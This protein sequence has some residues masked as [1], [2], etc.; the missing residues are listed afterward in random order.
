MQFYGNLQANQNVLPLIRDG[1]RLV[2]VSSS[3]GNL[4]KYSSAVQERFRLVKPVNDTTKLMEDF[5]AVVSQRAAKRSEGW[6]SA[7][8]ATSKPD[9]TAITTVLAE[10]QKAQGSKTLNNSCCP[11]Y[12]KVRGH[13][14]L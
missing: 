3:A 5:K 11:G 12:V 13:L 14:S 4:S 7:A 6:V 8:Y 2:N 9:V 10:E 1:G